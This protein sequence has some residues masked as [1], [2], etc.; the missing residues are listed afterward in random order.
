MTKNILKPEYSEMIDSQID[1]SNKLSESLDIDTATLLDELAVLGLV[2][3]PS[4]TSLPGE[5]K[6]NWASLAYFR[7]LGMSDSKI[8][9]N[10]SASSG[11]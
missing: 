10:F 1:F 2:L 3:M 4:T 5:E 11:R 6:T 7:T 9:E 8:S